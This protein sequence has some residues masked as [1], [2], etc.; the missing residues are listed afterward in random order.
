MRAVVGVTDNEWASFLR[1]R[2]HLSEANFWLPSATSTFR[3]LRT[4]EPFLFKTHHPHNRLVGGGFFSGYEAF[5]IREAW[6]L[7]GEGNGVTDEASLTRA[8]A[9]YRKGS[10][11]PTVRIGCVLLRD[12][13]FVSEDLALEAPSDFAKNIVRFKGYDLSLP[14]TE[15]E[16][17]VAELLVRAG[18]AIESVDGRSLHVPGPIRGLPLLI[19]PRVGQQAFKGLVLT[20]YLRRCAITGGRIEPTLQA[21]HIRPVSANGQHQ[22][23][24]GLLLRS[25]VHTLFDRGYLGVDERHRLHVSPRLR[26]DWGNGQEFYDLAGKNITVPQR[27]P[28]RPAKEFTTWHMDTVFQSV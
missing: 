12:L 10:P 13:F 6:E 19:Q 26:G 15:I 25:D 7:F 3:A 27:K 2:P 24:N 5:S 18:I 4:G 22:V 20:S 28:D 8:I 23:D 11:D 17:K 9:G 14:G 21:A 1:A 16:E